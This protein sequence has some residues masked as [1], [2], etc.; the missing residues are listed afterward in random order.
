M[1]MKRTISLLTLFILPLFCFAQT[2]RVIGIVQN[3]VYELNGGV[4]ASVGGRSRIVLPIEVPFGT[5]SIVYTI[6]AKRNGEPTETTFNLALRLGALLSGNVAV[7][8]AVSQLEIPPGS[9]TAE[10]CLLPGRQDADLFLAKRD[11]YWR[12]YAD[13]SR[14]ACSSCKVAVPYNYSFPRTVYLGIKNPSSLNA[15]TVIVNVSAVIN[16]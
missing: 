7:S 14:D 8:A 13:F 4:R 3:D 9:E 10:V 5:E 12:R 6:V 1:N 16:Q 2:H 11:G 15:V